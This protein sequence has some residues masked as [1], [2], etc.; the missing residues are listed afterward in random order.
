[1]AFIFSTSISNQET[2]FNE[3]VR[4]DCDYHGWCSSFY[5]WYAADAITSWL[6]RAI[7]LLEWGTVENKTLPWIINL[8]GE[9]VCEN[10][11]INNKLLSMKVVFIIRL[12]NKRT[13]LFI[14]RPTELFR[15]SISLLRT[16]KT[17]FF[18]KCHHHFSYVFSVDKLVTCY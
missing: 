2:R 14:E 4:C 12:N 5:T 15:K 8:N 10:T 16:V 18:F 1:M 17:V 9:A 13:L 7:L 3:Q 6:F 11:F